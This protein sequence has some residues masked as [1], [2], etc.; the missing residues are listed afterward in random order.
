[1]SVYLMGLLGTLNNNK[2]FWIRGKIH[3]TSRMDM[4][5]YQIMRMQLEV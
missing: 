2:T 5:V 4:E 1:M 3:N